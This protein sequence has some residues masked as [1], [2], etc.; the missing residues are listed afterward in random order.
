MKKPLVIGLAGIGIVILIVG[1]V[2]AFWALKDSADDEFQL[3]ETAGEGVDPATATSEV[4]GECPD[5]EPTSWTVGDGSEAGYR[6]DEVLRGLDKT[7]TGRTEDV[8]GELSLRCDGVD[9][10]TVT[11]QTGTITSDAALRDDRVRADY[12]QTDRFPTATFTLAKAIPL[13]GTPALGE[14]MSASAPGKLELHGVTR[15]VTVELDAQLTAEDR[16]EVVGSV[17]IA[18]A[19]YDIEVPDIAGIVTA[20]P[21]GRLEFKLALTPA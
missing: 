3:S 8:S 11:V 21:E 18:L 17:P 4:A 10:V 9:A 15:D 20:A 12:L 14:R 13:E 16:M 7:A 19:D 2:V 5:G 6:I 1:G